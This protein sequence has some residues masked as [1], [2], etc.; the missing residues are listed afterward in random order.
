MKKGRNAAEI[1]GSDGEFDM[2][3]LRG[4]ERTLFTKCS[5]PKFLSF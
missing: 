2:V 5:V 3:E 1:L 4:Q